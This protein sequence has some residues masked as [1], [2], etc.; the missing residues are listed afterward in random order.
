M[1]RPNVNF[2]ALTVPEIIAIGVSAFRVGVANPQSW[3]RGGRSG[4][5]MLPFE[6]A[7]VSSYRPP[8]VTFPL[9]L[10]VSEILPLLCSS[11][12]LFPHPTSSLHKFPHVSL[13]VGGW[14]LGFEERRCWVNCPCN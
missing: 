14:H 3:G 6:R 10:R 13:G 8:I 4:S 9:S 7:L 2:V 5:G 12:P 1:F 11:T